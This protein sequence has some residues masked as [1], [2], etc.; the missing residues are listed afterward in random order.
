[1][2]LEGHAPAYT[3]LAAGQ[4]LPAC[5]CDCLQGDPG[6]LTHATWFDALDDA[7]TILNH[8]IHGGPE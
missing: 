2:P 4:Y 1:M 8:R 3:M 5:R 7:S 6:L